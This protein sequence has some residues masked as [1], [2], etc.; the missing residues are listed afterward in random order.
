M[1]V[2]VKKPKGKVL[3][4]LIIINVKSMFMSINSLVNDSRLFDTSE[5]SHASVCQFFSILRT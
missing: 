4:V 1:V 3:F 2:C 5:P